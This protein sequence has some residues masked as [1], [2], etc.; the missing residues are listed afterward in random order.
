MGLL[1]RR[2]GLADFIETKRNETDQMEG[3]SLC[4]AVLL[5]RLKVSDRL[6]QRTL[7]EGGQNSLGEFHDG[8]F[9]S[10]AYRHG[11]DDT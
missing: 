2:Y 5:Q 7:V 1:E 4:T 6:F 10:L 3:E 8:C 9:S 11:L